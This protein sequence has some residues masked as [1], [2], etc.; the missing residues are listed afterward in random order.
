[1]EKLSKYQEELKH[2]YAKMDE[3]VKVYSSLNKI[4]LI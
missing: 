2:L 1:M 3:M 4:Q